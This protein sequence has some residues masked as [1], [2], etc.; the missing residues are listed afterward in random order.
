MLCTLAI[1]SKRKR[2]VALVSVSGKTSSTFTLV[3][4]IYVFT[5]GV[6]VTLF[7]IFSAFV[8]IYKDG[9]I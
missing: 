1:E 5:F 9:K 6:K 8:D 4:S 2:T 7:D 3:G